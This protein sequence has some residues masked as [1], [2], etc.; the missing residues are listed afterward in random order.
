M[1]PKPCAEPRLIV[2]YPRSYLVLAG[3]SGSLPPEVL[4][5][6][7]ALYKTAP[8]S[9]GRADDDF[10]LLERG[11]KGRIRLFYKNLGKKC[12]RLML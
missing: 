1:Y 10:L 5:S 12:L 2:N 4:I 9:T 3:F 8:R 6:G 11:F 7:V